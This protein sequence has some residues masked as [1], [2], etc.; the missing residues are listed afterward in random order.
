MHAGK[1]CMQ[2]SASAKGA[3]ALDTDVLTHTHTR[4]SKALVEHVRDRVAL[5]RCG[6]K[7]GWRFA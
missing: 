4:S 6:H 3:G 7:N 5:G 1:A 2:V